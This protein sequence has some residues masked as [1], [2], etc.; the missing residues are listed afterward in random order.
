MSSEWP[1]AKSKNQMSSK[2]DRSTLQVDR[3]SSFFFFFCTVDSPDCESNLVELLIFRMRGTSEASRTTCHQSA[4]CTD[5]MEVRRPRRTFG[6]TSLTE[7]IADYPLLAS[8][9]APPVLVV[10]V[11]LVPPSLYFSSLGGSLSFLK[12]Q[13]EVEWNS[14]TLLSITVRFEPGSTVLVRYCPTL[15]ASFELELRFGRTPPPR[16]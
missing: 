12:R 3:R 14:S 16:S 4:D 15:A 9:P 6:F 11:A 5:R 10:L 1:Q 7:C 8:G 13:Y 2:A